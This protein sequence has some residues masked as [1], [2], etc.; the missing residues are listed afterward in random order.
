[1][2]ISYGHKLRGGQSWN[3]SDR[4]SWAIVTH[5]AGLTLL[6]MGLVS[7]T[8]GST[9]FARAS[10]R[11]QGPDHGGSAAFHMP[12]PVTVEVASPTATPTSTPTLAPSATSTATAS[13]TLTSTP[14]ATATSTPT[15]TSTPTSTSTP[16]PEPPTATP[17]PVPLAKP[18][19]LVIPRIGL[20][21]P[22]FPV[23]PD[24]NGNLVVLK[25]DV[26]WY[27]RSGRP[28]GGTN[29]I[30]WAHV[31]RWK[32]AP[33]VPAP[34]ADV[35]LL[36]PG[37]QV[38]VVNAHGERFRYAVTKQIRVTPDQVEYLAPTDHERIMLVSCIGD[39]VIVGG[40]LTKTQRLLTIAEPID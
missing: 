19:R 9:D 10:H 26:G 27:E 2:R 40:E 12:M 29:V 28:G 5:R 30:F 37:N 24:G 34:F 6:L 20:D 13:A 22:V 17:T 21:T 25:H 38:I 11:A 39:N 36:E 7:L 3:L 18:D 14:T 15:P 4:V 32:S 1:M 8:T 23:G 31:L 35:H 16:T 33:D